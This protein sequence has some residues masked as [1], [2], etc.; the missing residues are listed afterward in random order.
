MAPRCNP[1]QNRQKVGYPGGCTLRYIELGGGTRA[2]DSHLLDQVCYRGG[3]GDD[4]SHSTPRLQQ[5][6]RQSVEEKLTKL[7]EGLTCG[8][9]VG[10]YI[11][12]DDDKSIECDSDVIDHEGD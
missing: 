7:M 5:M 2:S 11:G 12:A 8:V 6:H 4:R 10:G 1:H 9:S 3:D